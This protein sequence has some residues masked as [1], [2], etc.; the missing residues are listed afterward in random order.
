MFQEPV[1]SGNFFFCCF[2]S[3]GAMAIAPLFIHNAYIRHLL[4]IAMIYAVVAASW[5]LSLGYA[6]VFN[7]AHLA[8]LCHRRIHWRHLSQKSGH[9]ALGCHSRRRPYGICI[10][11]SCLY[12]SSQSQGDLCLSGHLCIQSVVASC[13]SQPGR[14][15]R[16]KSWACINT[17][18]FSCWLQL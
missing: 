16:R 17:A 11:S 2:F 8:F 10:R 4:I 15:N 9:P 13:Y 14:N 6:G 7:F 3:I 5:D 18:V 12:T 1:L